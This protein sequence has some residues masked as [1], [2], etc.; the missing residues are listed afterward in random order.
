VLLTNLCRNKSAR[1]VVKTTA[2]QSIVRKC[3]PPRH[4]LHC[5]PKQFT[6]NTVLLSSDIKQQHV[7]VAMKKICPHSKIKWVL[8]SSSSNNNPHI[9]LIDIFQRMVSV[10]ERCAL[11]YTPTLT[12][13]II[14]FEQPK[15]TQCNNNYAVRNRTCLYC[16]EG[17]LYVQK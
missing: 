6:D 1:R 9:Y 13:N 14:F 2:R 4:R 15:C 12:Q 16:R 5:A 7:T 10:V 17:E 3:L 11:A 8:N